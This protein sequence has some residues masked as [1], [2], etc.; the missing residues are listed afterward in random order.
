MYIYALSE[1]DKISRALEL[2]TFGGEC[3]VKDG[4]TYISSECVWIWENL[5]YTVDYEVFF[6][7]DKYYPMM[8]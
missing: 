7:N 4:K 1:N 5:S 6:L 8:Q 3:K 2:H